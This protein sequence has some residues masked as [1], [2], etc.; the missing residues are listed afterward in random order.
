MRFVNLLQRSRRLLE[1]KGVAFPVAA[2]WVGSNV[3]II[4]VDFFDIGKKAEDVAEYACNELD[5]NRKN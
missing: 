2:Q 3:G 5:F 1:K 4:Y